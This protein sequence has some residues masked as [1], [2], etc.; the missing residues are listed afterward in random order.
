MSFITTYEEPWVRVAATWA[1][2]LDTRPAGTTAAATPRAL[3]GVIL[4]ANL[5]LQSTYEHLVYGDDEEVERALNNQPLLYG[6]MAK[7]L[8]SRM[9]L[10]G[11]EC[12]L[13]FICELQSR[14][15][16]NW[17]LAGELISLI[18]SPRYGEAGALADYQRA[19]AVGRTDTAKCAGAY[20]G[21]SVSAFQWGS[22]DET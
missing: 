17:T 15:V 19:A 6:E 3:Y 13:R 5:L 4:V 16:E 2:A 18:F 20:L 9:G 14:P 22:F 21:C 7:Q 12:V 1:Q 10:D 11:R 8:T